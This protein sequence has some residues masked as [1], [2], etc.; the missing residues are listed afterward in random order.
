MRALILDCGYSSAALREMLYVR[1]ESSGGA[2]M[3]GIMIY[4]AAADSEGSLGGLV[5]QGQPDRL[6]LLLNDA[7]ETARWCSND[8]LC[9]ESE[10]QGMNSLNMAACHSCSLVPETACEM[11]NGFLD[12][13]VVIGTEREPNLAFFP[14]RT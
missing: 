12:R 8:P 13:G 2:A 5:R 9:L 10:S 6:G 7:V 3:H 4:T 11:F 14:A 1:P